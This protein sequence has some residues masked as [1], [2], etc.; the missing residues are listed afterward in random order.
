M[1]LLTLMPENTTM[2]YENARKAAINNPDGFGF[3]IHSQEKIMTDHDMDFEKL[4]QRFTDARKTMSGPALFH[5][6]IAT[7][8]ATNID[9]CHPFQ[10]GDD[11]QS[12]IAHNGILPLTM[13]VQQTRS[14]TRL[15]AE[16]VLPA[17]GG[18]ARLDDDIFF[19]DL[20]HWASGNK[21]VVMTINPDA[22]Y[23]WYIINEPE[24]HWTDGVWYSNS[25]Y[26]WVYTTYATSYGTTYTRRYGT[27]PY[28][29]GMYSA[30]DN[31]WDEGY[32]GSPYLGEDTKPTRT[33][34]LFDDPQDDDELISEMDFHTWLL[35]EMYDG[36]QAWV[37]QIMSFTDFDIGESA[38]SSALVSCGSCNA[39]T[40]VDPT[41]ISHT[42]C[43]Q[44]YACLVCHEDTMCNCWD[45]FE[46]HQSFTPIDRGD[47]S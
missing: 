22:K 35:E 34:S 17:C 29:H 41:E 14:D 24:G 26:R 31:D 1:C 37:D 20:E 25:S 8:G 4:W 45:G 46:Y 44:C 39:L 19:K 23:D 32:V 15:F 10:I 3:A 47:I 13:P 28:R 38:W 33:E 12:F 27:M 9:N 43:G 2:S 16:L 18:V 5:F 42:H 7:H 21:M 11:P 6:R 36:D 30:W 40:I